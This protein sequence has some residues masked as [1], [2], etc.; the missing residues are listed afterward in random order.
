VK[1]TFPVLVMQQLFE[2]ADKTNVSPAKLTV[3]AVSEYLSN[4]KE[5]TISGSKSDNNKD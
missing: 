5:I 4:H 1:I 2:L 3:Q